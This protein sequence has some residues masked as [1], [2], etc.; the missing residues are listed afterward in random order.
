MTRDQRG[1]AVALVVGEG[2]RIEQRVLTVDRAIGD[3]W[4]VTG[5]V[6]AG[7]RIVVEGVQKVRPG[8]EVRVVEAAS[9][10]RRADSR[11][12]CPPR[13]DDPAQP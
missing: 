10:G 3:Q 12:P 2:S 6:A 7:D 13:A 4:L 1:Q 8:A 9:P 5:G 11:A